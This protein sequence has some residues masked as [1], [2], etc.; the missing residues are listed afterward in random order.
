MR[1]KDSE[2]APCVQSDFRPAAC[3]AKPVGI[4]SGAALPALGKEKQQN[5]QGR[6][7]GLFLVRSVG[8]RI[9]IRKDRNL[10]DHFAKIFRSWFLPAASKEAD[11]DDEE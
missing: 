1:G 9:F 11:A 7:E 2:S 4:A 6:T 10:V 5:R 8:R 3:D